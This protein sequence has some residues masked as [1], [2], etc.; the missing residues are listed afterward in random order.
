MSRIETIPNDVLS[1]IFNVISELSQ[2]VL[3]KMDRRMLSQNLTVPDNVYDMN[4]IPQQAT[5]C[6]YFLSFKPFNNAPYQ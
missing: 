6:K 3:I 4:W 2:T 1:K 5:L